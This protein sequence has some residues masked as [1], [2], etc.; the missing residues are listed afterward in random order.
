MNVFVPVS[1]ELM[2]R[3]GLSPDDLV[4]FDLEYEVLRPGEDF[5]QLEDPAA[6][7]AG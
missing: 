3:L 7:S 2:D 1:D 5:E 6:G 4:P